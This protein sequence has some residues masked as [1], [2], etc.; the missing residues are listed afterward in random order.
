MHIAVLDPIVDH[1][2][3]IT[4]PALADVGYARAVLH[5]G[6]D[7]VEDILDVEVGLVGPAGHEGRA[8][9]RPILA[10][11]NPHAEIQE[12]FSGGLGDAALGV[13]VPLVAAVD[14]GVAGLHVLGQGGDG[15]VDGSPG[16]DEDDNRSR[17]LNRQNE[18]AGIGTLSRPRSRPSSDP[19]RPDPR[20]LSGT[21]L[22]QQRLPWQLN[23][24][25][26]K[27]E[28]ESFPVGEHFPLLHILPWQSARHVPP[29]AHHL[30]DSAVKQKA[31]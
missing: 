20:V 26:I 15:L 13:L 29:G 21:E 10:A 8:V 4:R 30:S 28:G 24:R 18:I 27:I 7:L 3:E 22:E 6:G 9:S 16:L 1:F 12:S 17:A 25:K 5:L 2:D 23:N 14:D 11:G 31:L 19:S